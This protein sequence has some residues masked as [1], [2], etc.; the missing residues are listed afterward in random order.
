MIQIYQQNIKNQLEQFDFI[1]NKRLNL[2]I[3]IPKDMLVV[4]ETK[5]VIKHIIEIKK[6]KNYIYYVYI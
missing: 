4:Y 2:I 3:I 6:K 5:N 1:A